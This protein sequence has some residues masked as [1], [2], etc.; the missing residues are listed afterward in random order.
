[1]EGT[2]GR[3]DEETTEM[4]EVEARDGGTVKT[5]PYIWAMLRIRCQCNCWGEERRT[6]NVK[7]KMLM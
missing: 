1:M 2:R 7:D 4:R 5:V 6:G 3:G